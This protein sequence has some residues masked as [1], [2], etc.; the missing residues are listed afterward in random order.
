[1][2]GSLTTATH[3]ALLRGIN[4]GTAKR[5]A[6]ADL[7]ECFTELGYGAV[8]TLLNSGNAVFSAPGRAS[9]QTHAARIETRLAEHLGFAVPVVVK[10]ASAIAATVRSQPLAA[11]ANNDSRLMLTFAQDDADLAVLAPLCDQD[12]GLERLALT[13]HAAWM[14]CPAG[15]IDSP[16]AKAAAK[17]L[18]ERGTTRNWATVQKIHALLQLV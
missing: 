14:W 3:V 16:L 4:V 2:T 5:V 18:S 15:I 7:R 1:M 6:M 12:W 13:P 11:V 10:P 8:Q 17:R 9:G